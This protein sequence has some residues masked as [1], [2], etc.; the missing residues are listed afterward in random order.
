MSEGLSYVVV[1][2]VDGQPPAVVEQAAVFARHFGAQ[3]ICA[4]VDATRYVVET[5]ADGTVTTLPLDP[6]VAEEREEF[7]DEQLLQ[8]VAAIMGDHA[9]VPWTARAL[10]GDPADAL[11]ELADEVDARMIV[12]G[13]REASFWGAMHEFLN[14]SVAAQ[15]AHH[16]HRPVV[17][18]P[19]N[20]VGHDSRPSPR[21]G[22][23]AME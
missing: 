12:V 7:F 20:P 23:P 15:L 14:G 17:V 10:A 8:Q 22:G 18:I 5:R 6:D 21:D 3:L 11:A 16:Q 13:T 2:V 19:L 1:G 9:E 4:G